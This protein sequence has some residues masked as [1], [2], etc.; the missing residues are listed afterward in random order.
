[1]I[2]IK[3]TQEKTGVMAWVGDKPIYADEIRK[4]VDVTT[5]YDPQSWNP[6]NV[7]AKKLFSCVECLRD[8]DV[9]LQTAGR[10]KNKAKQR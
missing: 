9:L 10:L 6:A 7:A 8:I 4:L 3:M 1:M 5:E 2:E